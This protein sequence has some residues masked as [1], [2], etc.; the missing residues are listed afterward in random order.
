MGKGAWVQ[1]VVLGT[2]LLLQIL[3]QSVISMRM[4]VFSPE[5]I[6]QMRF[7]LW[8]SEFIH[9]SITLNMILRIM[10]ANLAQVVYI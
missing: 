2:L 8:T 5:A 7:D 3:M 10:G 9:L 6:S 4:P 1:N